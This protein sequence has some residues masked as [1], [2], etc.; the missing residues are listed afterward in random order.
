MIGDSLEP[1]TARC[2]TVFTT[3]WAN[4]LSHFLDFVTDFY[5]IIFAMQIFY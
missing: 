4:W 5:S 2:I 1:T 3:G